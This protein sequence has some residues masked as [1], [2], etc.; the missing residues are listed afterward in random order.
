LAEMCKALNI[1]EVITC[2]TIQPIKDVT[3]HTF[4][5]AEDLRVNVID[6]WRISTSLFFLSS[7]IF[8]RKL[9][10]NNA[11]PTDVAV[12]VCDDLKQPV[13]ITHY[14]ILSNAEGFAQ[15][16]FM[17]HND[18]MLA[19]ASHQSPL[20][21]IGQLWYPLLNAVGIACTNVEAERL[22]VATINALMRQYKI[23]LLISNSHFYRKILKSGQSL[24]FPNVRFAVAI[25][26]DQDDSI[27]AEFEEKIHVELFEGFGI[28]QMPLLVS[29]NHRNYISGN[30]K[31]VG[32]K[33]GSVGKPLP[34]ILVKIV[35]AKTGHELSFGQEGILMLKGA[36]IPLNVKTVDGWIDTQRRASIDEDGF[37]H[38]IAE[39][40][41]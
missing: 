40:D 38:L 29:L 5:K 15:L 22:T 6:R 9:L 4:N 28:P 41:A 1:R 30:L 20:G 37:I 10:K 35:D 2:G 32:T 17:R 19:E 33:K 36:N 12:V 34:G 26:T 16:L 13:H 18:W 21:C 7:N 11:A 27:Y 24:T 31:Q 14:N 23:T 39:G 8:V 3:L 25:G